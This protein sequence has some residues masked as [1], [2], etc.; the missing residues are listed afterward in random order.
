M[1]GRP[2]DLL[3]GL[4][5]FHGF[6]QLVLGIVQ[7]LLGLGAVARHVVVVGGARTLHLVDR[8]L[9]VLVNG[10]EIVPVV[11]LR[12]ER[13]AGHEPNG[14][15]NNELLH[16][17]LSEEVGTRFVWSETS[18][19]RERSVERRR[20]AGDYVFVTCDVI[21]KSTRMRRARLNGR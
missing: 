4:G 8:F 6:V 12:G 2:A 19:R 20:W 5:S 15:G 9:D 21:R 7:Q 1:R 17:D 3:G 18:T 11:H 14:S 16:T 13:H 10:I